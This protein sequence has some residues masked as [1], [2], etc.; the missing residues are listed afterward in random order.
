MLYIDFCCSRFMYRCISLWHQ[1][2]AVAGIGAYALV[3]FRILVFVL[4]V[5]E[6]D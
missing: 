5:E 2:T 6:C 3:F 1:C 4:Q